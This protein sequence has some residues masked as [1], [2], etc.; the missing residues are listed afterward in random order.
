[1]SQ[2][3]NVTVQ[4]VWMKGINVPGKD[5][6]QIRQDACGAYI[7]RNMYGDRTSQNN[8]GWEIDHI[9]PGGSDNISNLRP[10]QWNNNAC[11]QDGPLSCPVTAQR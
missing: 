1:M 4:L 9:I 7:A 10:L 6:T 8:N 3:D 11:R 5:P 2:F